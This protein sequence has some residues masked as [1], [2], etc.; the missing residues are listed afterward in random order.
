MQSTKMYAMR[1][2]HDLMIKIEIEAAR[3]HMTKAQ[4]IRSALWEVFGDADVIDG[5]SL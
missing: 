3:R 5:Q 2:E 4:V 1:I